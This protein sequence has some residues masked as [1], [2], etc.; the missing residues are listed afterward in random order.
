MSISW[1]SE[2]WLTREPS[3]DAVYSLSPAQNEYFDT[4][5]RPKDLFKGQQETD[6]NAPDFMTL[7]PGIDLVQ[8]VTTD[9]S[10]VAGLSAAMDILTGK[11][12]VCPQ[13]NSHATIAREW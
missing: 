5:T 13:A 12:A 11:E 6:G 1:L 9:C 2:S 4:W 10:V 8:D 3:D 7:D